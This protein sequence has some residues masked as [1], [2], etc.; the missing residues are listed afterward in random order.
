MMPGA[1][2]D[3]ARGDSGGG[4]GG[5]GDNA[6]APAAAGGDRGRALRRPLALLPPG[7]GLG[8][9]LRGQLGGPGCLGECLG[10][11]GGL[12]GGRCRCFLRGRR[13]FCFSA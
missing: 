5:A 6:A 13:R 7:L 8:G 10:L 1:L 3:P 11:S 4:G 2:A 9:L 12:L